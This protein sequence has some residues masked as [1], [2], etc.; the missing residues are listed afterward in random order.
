MYEED[1]VKKVICQMVADTTD[2]EALEYRKEQEEIEI[3]KIER[4]TYSV[5]E[6]NKELLEE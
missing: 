6:E 5:I 3:I 1:Y 2:I 4:P